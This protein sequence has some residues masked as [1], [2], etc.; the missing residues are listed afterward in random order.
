ME[1]RVTTAGPGRALAILGLGLAFVVVA[2]L[3][4]GA[5]APGS[6]RGG[7]SRATRPGRSTAATAPGAARVKARY[8]RLPLSFE[9]NRGQAPRGVDFVARGQG[10]V[11]LLSHGAARIMFPS[12]PSKPVRSP[13][14]AGLARDRVVPSARAA[15]VGLRFAGAA[16]RPRAAGRRRLPGTVSYFEGHTRS[17][18][19]TGIPTYAR[20]RYRSLYRGV[21]VVFHGDQRRLEYD[22]VLAPGADPSA[23]RLLVSGGRALLDRGDLVVRA[24]ATSMRLH[25]PRVYQVI[26]GARRPVAGAY[27]LKRSASGAADRVGFSIGRYDR[28]RPLTIDPVL[29][30]ST[31]LGGSLNEVVSAVAGDSKLSFYVAGTTWSPDF[32]TPG[33]DNERPGGRTDVFV[34]KLLPSASQV[35]YQV[36]LGGA[37]GTVGRDYANG[38]AVDD[39]GNAY[40]AGSTQAPDF[41]VTNDSF[42]PGFGGDHYERYGGVAYEG[43]GDAFVSVLN[44][45]GTGFVYSTFLGGARGDAANSIA[46]T[47]DGSALVTGVT[48]SFDLAFTPATDEGFPT[49]NSALEKRDRDA[50]VF[51]AKLKPGGADLDYSV[52]LG[53]RN[54]EEGQGVAVDAGG[55]A[56]VTGFTTSSDDPKT[57]GVNEGF[58]TKDAFQPDSGGRIPD[59]CSFSAQLGY[60]NCWDAFVAKLDTSGGLTYSSYLGRQGDD[61]GSSIAVDPTG[62]AYVAGTSTS[63]EMPWTSELQNGGAASNALVAKVAPSGRSL[64]YLA[65]IG[66]N[67]EDMAFGVAVDP[68][69]HAHVAGLTMSGELLGDLPQR[70]TSD[71]PAAFVA[72]LATEG[73][74]LDYFTYL[75]GTSGQSAAA[76]IS[77]PLPCVTYVAG[78]TRSADFPV[79]GDALQHAYAGDGLGGH[80]FEPRY[81]DG[82]VASVVE[83]A[84]GDGIPDCWERQPLDVNHDGV[85]D[86]DLPKLGARPDHKDIFVEVDWMEDAT[87]SDRP[88]ERA[89]HDVQEAFRAALVDNPD[90]QTG[91]R[92]HLLPDTQQGGVP[93]VPNLVLGG[94]GQPNDFQD[95]KVGPSGDPCAQGPEPHGHFGTPSDRASPNCK[96]ILAAKALV[97]RYA[98]FGD[99]FS[100]PGK[101]SGHESGIAKNP[102]DDLLVT[103]GAWSRA[104]I[105]DADDLRAAQAGTLMHE[106]GHTLGL[107]HG[108]RRPVDDQHQYRTVPDD[109][110]C[111]PN[112]PSV[113]SYTRQLPNL[114]P[115]R[116]LDYSF[117]SM[118]PLDESNLDETEPLSP[119]LHEVIWGFQGNLQT[120]TNDGLGNDWNAD[121]IR[122]SGVSADINWLKRWGCKTPDGLTVLTDHADWRNL[123]YDFRGSAGYAAGAPVAAGGE[124]TADEVIAG[125]ES[126]DSDGD[127]L[128][129]AADNCPAV[130]NPGQQDRNG[131]GYGDACSVDAVLVDPANARR[132]GAASGTVVLDRPAPAGGTEIAFESGDPAVTVPDHITV[133]AGSGSAT[134][135][136]GVGAQ[137][138]ADVTITA[139]DGGQSVAGRLGVSDEPAPMANLQLD[140]VAA[141]RAVEGDPIPVSVRVTNRGAASTFAGFE[142]QL[143]GDRG[144]PPVP[145]D[146]PA[147]RLDAQ[148][149][150]AGESVELS[151]TLPAGSV[152]AGRHRAWALADGRDAITEERESDNAAATLVTVGP[153]SPPIVS[154]DTYRAVDT[155]PLNVTAPGVLANDSDAEGDRLTATL[156]DGPRHGTLDLR[157]DG[158]FRYTPYAAGFTGED[159]FTYRASDGSADSDL[160]RVTLEL[161]TAGGNSLVSLSTAGNQG[162]AGESHFPRLSADGTVVAFIS[163]A[164]GLSPDDHNNDQLDPRDVFVRDR[165]TGETTLATGGPGLTSIEFPAISGDGRFVAF[166]ALH[167]TV[168]PND[169]RDVFIVDR[170]TGLRERVSEAPGALPGN[171]ASVDP[172]LSRD[173]RFVAFTSRASNLVPDDTN[174]L[175]DVFVRD[176]QTGE[177][178]RVSVKSD[179]EEARFGNPICCPAADARITTDGRFV[180]FTSFLS[181]LVPGDTNQEPD[182]FVH[183]RQTGETTRVNTATASDHQI[184]ASDISADGSVIVYTAETRTTGQMALFS[185]ERTTGQ[186]TQL[187]VPRAHTAYNGGLVISGDGRRIVFVNGPYEGPPAQVYVYD[188]TT[189]Q[190]SLVSVSRN[191]GPGDA[192]SA[193]DYGTRI[194][195]D[196]DGGVIAFES[197]SDD[198]VANDTNGQIDVFAHSPPSGVP[199]PD[200]VDLSLA[201]SAAPDPVAGGDQLQYTLTARNA[202]PADAS[203]VTVE[204][205][206]PGDVTFVSADSTSG[207]CTGG[208]RVTCRIG[209]LA[210]T[211]TA[212]VTVT[213]TT[214]RPGTIENSASVGA[215]ESD[216]NS[217]DNTAVTRIVVAA[218]PPSAPTGAP[219]LSVLAFT[220]ESVTTGHPVPVAISV[221]NHGDASAAPSHVAVFADAAPTAGD[222]PLATAA[223]PALSDG[224]SAHVDLSLDG[225]A[226]APGPHTLWALA[227]ARG[228]VAEAEENDNLSRTPVTIAPVVPD[229]T[230]P[231]LL[232]APTGPLLLSEPVS[233]PP[234]RAPTAA[235]D[236]AAV[237]AGAI[238]TVPWP[239]VLRN[240]G[241]ADGDPVTVALAAPAQHGHV[242]LDPDGSYVY[243][244]ASGFA[245]ADSFRYS[246]SDGQA[247]SAPAT[248]HI[249]VRGDSG[250]GGPPASPPPGATPTGRPPSTPPGGP[251]AVTV[252]I[253]RI[254]RLPSAHRCVSRRH[255][256]IHLRRLASDPVVRAT[257]GIKGQ[258]AR[259]VTGRALGLPIDLRGL[260]KG[261]FTVVVTVTTKTGQRMV[262]RRRYRTCVPRRTQRPR[263]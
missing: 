141:A 193:W 171:G 186:T 177:T 256:R 33:S 71:V 42:Q 129:N 116:R 251:A 110:N 21:D 118:A 69:G 5:V 199:P 148:A 152:P 16:P 54:N 131:D 89:L 40:V 31:Y 56:Y 24:A 19:R 132:G 25:K 66:G 222:T 224:A 242:A 35:D 27:S 178:T 14:P 15:S 82:Y 121:G 140:A 91:I 245:G 248:V 80:S 228:E 17:R 92:L 93:D 135:P 205:T 185:Y 4:V 117:G 107:G 181:D 197:Q 50:D 57:A 11:A 147:T 212:T 145:G 79:T 96:Q 258:T 32:L 104:A 78:S 225:G 34:A 94:P 158:S 53:G 105:R 154:N 137:S 112:Y 254:A 241:D 29:G 75:A 6:A 244:P 115:W 213:V 232:H 173:G 230:T 221:T 238:L 124:L 200:P 219:D 226:L 192:A 167:T 190:T 67:G 36:Y 26:G 204:D 1:A 63:A 196:A 206:L 168:N 170:Q 165:T 233:A 113:M 85:A 184:G 61:W 182:L 133:S 191:G 102:G 23:V 123:V 128:S 98:L 9:A 188:R 198:L 151:G 160:A 134:F 161:Q 44:P 249:T 126:V 237:D 48:H 106:L 144:G 187:D 209:A 120:E 155:I 8:S 194:A 87:H 195:I 18:W 74:S 95:L 162:Y 109:T 246:V 47:R 250:S 174:G 156:V 22:L 252:A 223:V 136:I 261:R 142:V 125:A 101:P 108:G 46:V 138:P 2:T 247:A 90:G 255:F 114:D 43:S 122:T 119:N 88:L 41:P 49:K 159:T 207:V 12:R 166:D 146:A 153:T 175:A 64:D 216:P 55:S 81:G 211:A 143:F 201:A 97:F 62:A 263:H 214:D 218:P 163:D 99:A 157:P 180:L 130:A 76:A 13:G 28:R 39:A 45:N 176:R 150:A 65:R 60:A 172:A 10:Y 183:D 100:E 86:L 77:V 210:A 127:G 203:G 103:L 227:D 260:P 52:L 3:A 59:Q 84:D 262:G 239:G 220:A 20:V 139:Y 240:D 164:F 73:R 234:N 208:A 7:L 68:D 243:T 149:L 58:P 179:G 169:A 235:D 38:I 253:D 30:A 51:L 83:D 37:G 111:K 259:I 257:I 202:G 72:K 229:L 217:A 215:T 236:S 231:D 189:G 70:V